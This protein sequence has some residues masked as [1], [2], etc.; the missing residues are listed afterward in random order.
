MNE[1]NDEVAIGREELAKKIIGEI[2]LSAQPS[3]TIRKWR[4][5]FGIQ[6]KKLAQAVG[7]ASS[8]ISDYE[9]GRR[10]SPGILFVRK[11]VEGLIRIDEQT[12]GE[13]LKN[14]V[15]AVV[16]PPASAAVLDIK[17]FRRSVRVSRFCEL[18]GATLIDG[19]SSGEE[20]IFGYT[21][22]DSV[23]AI[24]ELS[25]SELVKLYGVTTQRAL[26]FTKVTVGKGPMIALKVVN[27]HPGL[28]VLYGVDKNEVS[29]VAKNIARIENIPLAVCGEKSIEELTKRLKSIE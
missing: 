28:V 7:V 11:Y 18:V 29:D 2:A 25:F 13:V 1:P 22:I 21:V 17:E 3:E 8:V 9:S 15:R 26:I 12:G 16:S 4:S 6:Q 24:T 27:L 5:L 23:K 14:F 19:T 20:E 10:K